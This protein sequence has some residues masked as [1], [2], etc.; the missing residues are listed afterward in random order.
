[1][2]ERVVGIYL[3]IYIYIKMSI[4]TNDNPVF[5]VHTDEIILE[6]TKRLWIPPRFC[7]RKL[8]HAE[9]TK[10]GKRARVVLNG[11]GCSGF[12]LPGELLSATKGT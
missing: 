10:F 6:E 11:A 4:A 8:H 12:W 1:V 2:N 7:H 9:L 3:H 5:P